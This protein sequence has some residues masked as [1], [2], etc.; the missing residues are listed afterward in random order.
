LVGDGNGYP[1]GGPQRRYDTKKIL[2]RSFKISKCSDH[3]SRPDGV[4][5]REDPFIIVFIRGG[6]SNT[7]LGRPRRGIGLCVGAITP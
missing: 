1:E 3:V 6:C 7:V 2:K 4:A 5:R